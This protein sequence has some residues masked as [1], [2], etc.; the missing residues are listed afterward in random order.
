[1]P[2]Q[3]KNTLLR[4]IVPLGAMA[5]GLGVAAAVY[6]NTTRQGQAP[7][8]QP[9]PQPAPPG[10]TGQ[11]GATGGATGPTGAAGPTGA[12]APTVTIP[13]LRAQPVTDA[14]A[15]LD[16]IGSLDPNGPF[17]AE[18]RFSP[19]GA[20]LRTVGLSR[21][22][23]TI[24]KTDHVITQ[25]EVSRPGTQPPELQPRATLTPLAAV[26]IRVGTGFVDLTGFEDQNGMTT[27]T[28]VWRQLAPG[29]FE[30]TVVDGT[31][32]PVVRITRR[33][34]LAPGSYVVRLRQRVENLTP[35]ALPIQWYQFGTLEL[36][37][38]VGYGGDKR[39]I[40]F[41]YLLEPRLQGADP[42]VLTKDFI[43]PRS[44]A[45]GP[46]LPDGTH[47]A[48]HELWPNLRSTQA[49]Y[50]LVWLGMTN[51]YFSAALHPLVQPGAH[52]DGKVFTLA[53]TVQRLLLNPADPQSALA[54][55]TRSAEFTLP[56]SGALDLD[57][58]FYP[59][60]LSRAAINT[61]PAATAAGV[62]GLIVYNFG[63]MCGWCTFDFL[64]AA[65]L[66]L[67]RLVYTVLQ[68][69][70]LSIMVLVL[71]V[72]LILHPVTKWSQI[73]M[74]RFGKQMQGMAPKQKKIQEKYGSDPKKMREE[75]ARLWREEGVSPTG[76]LGCIPLF[77]QTPVWIAL[78]ATLY[79]AFELRH[80]AAFYGVFQAI[81]PASWPTWWFLGDLSEPDRFLYFG[82]PGFKIPFIG[83]LFGPINS[84]NILPLILGVVFFIQQKYLTPPAA[85]GS[86][87]PEQEQ[88]Q[89]MM[90][91][92]MVVMFPLLMYPAPSGLALYFIVNSTLGIL[93]SRYIRAH[94][95]KYDKQQGA[96]GPGG[97]KGAGPKK[98]GPK[99]G[100][101]LARLQ[102]MA[103]ER[104]KQMM[105]AK[106]QHP[107]RKRV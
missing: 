5:L 64:T 11:A 42:T 29:A 75:M 9:A 101:F 94:M 8:T 104:Q 98:P 82:G 14:P 26:S 45:L 99:P 35:S 43:W 60:P 88:Q 28:P 55:Q 25:H 105:K 66:A 12:P 103:E 27:F 68:D 19:I 4:V 24:Q 73:R 34:E 69:W 85:P 46:E 7:A 67:L 52:P 91:W 47:P 6:F 50:R 18:L 62:D 74:Q 36:D 93:E 1:M 32:A 49:S 72:R 106:G 37:E 15:T 44:D 57:A 33:Y 2:P 107:P 100:G 65:L 102:A 21:H 79:F 76:M 23:Q 3:P 61:D 16:P 31:G 71:I 70:A 48:L 78:Y 87:T 17:M 41:G 90:K 59:G 83:D 22:F 77:L 92:M 95:D 40:R 84:L 86:L 39:R 38:T 56:A 81:Q 20:G 54:F 97:G 13:G 10:P 53:T 58:G 51:R 89:K 80:S 30:A 96:G 63:G